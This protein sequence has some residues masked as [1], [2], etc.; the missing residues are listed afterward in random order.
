MDILKLNKIILSGILAT[1]SSYAKNV[2]YAISDMHTLTL[3]KGAVELV[4]TYIKLNDQLDVLNMRQKELAGST[5]YNSVGN[6]SGYSLGARYGI[7]DNLMI[8]YTHTHQQLEY[9]ANK[10][11]NNRDDIYMRYNIVQNSF[12]YLN[13]GLSVD[14]GF[15]MNRL[16]DFYVRD[17]ET[18]NSLINK[19]LPNTNAEL[20]YSDG[21]TAFPNE[22]LPRSQG[23]YTYFN[24]TTTKLT[25]DPYVTLKDT[26]DKSV[27]FRLLT[28]RYT[29]DYLIDFY[30]GYKRTKIKNL[31]TTTQ[32]IITLG[33]NQGYDLEKSLNRDEQ[34]LFSGANYS[35]KAGSFIYEFNYEYE[36][37]LRDS[38]LN[39]IS[40]NHVFK[41]DIAYLMT[42]N[43]MVFAG[44]KLM[45]RQFNGQI[46]YLYNKYTQTAYN[47]KY[48]YATF[49]AQYNF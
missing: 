7:S 35:T 13:S 16:D 40:S 45:Y 26:N 20:R 34:T 33:T 41:A 5:T 28:G 31:I 10:L 23:Y 39:Y 25:N 43:F 12:A 27:Y 17:I 22:P 4:G 1:T 21:V 44:G 3:K 48:G 37:F 2:E 49:G 19:V 29:D 18:I 47:H 30:V 24:N 46:P 32:E 11:F 15:V 42:K 38:G 14:V 9:S 8:S 6:L 36:Y